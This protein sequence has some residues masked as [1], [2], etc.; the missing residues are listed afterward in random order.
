MLD[1]DE[2][3]KLRPYYFRMLKRLGWNVVYDNN[4]KLTNTLI[5]VS[6]MLQREKE[7]ENHKKHTEYGFLEVPYTSPCS[8]EKFGEQR[9][10]PNNGEFA[11][12]VNYVDSLIYPYDLDDVVCQLLHLGYSITQVYTVQNGKLALKLNRTMIEGLIADFVKKGSPLLNNE[13]LRRPHKIKERRPIKT[14]VNPDVFF[15]R[16]SQ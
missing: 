5:D 3:Q 16:N 12:L 9:L 15:G 8:Y 1:P 6:V 4:K 7:D 2:K 11:K 13:Q 14:F 10:H